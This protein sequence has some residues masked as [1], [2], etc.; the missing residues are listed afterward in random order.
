VEGGCESLSAFDNDDDDDALE[1]S[2]ADEARDDFADEWLTAS[3]LDFLSSS[4]LSF[5]L[6][7]A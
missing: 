5:G 7:L 1:S 2:F 6:D 3:F 4:L